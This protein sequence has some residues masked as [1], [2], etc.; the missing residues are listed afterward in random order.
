[1]RIFQKFDFSAL[2]NARSISRID[3]LGLGGTTVF[4]FLL[5][6]WRTA[7]GLPYL[8]HWDEHYVA[9]RSLEMLVTR[10]LNPHYFHYGS[11]QMYLLLAID[12]VHSLYLKALPGTSLLALTEVNPLAYGE[13]TGFGWYLS[14][15]SFLFWNRVLTVVLGALT[16]AII[17]YLGLKLANRFSAVAAALLLAGT[18][19]HVK[20]SA[21]VTTDIPMGFFVWAAVLFSYLFHQNQKLKFLIAALVTSGL[22]VSVKYN[23]G[24]VMLVPV[25]VLFLTR[26]DANY[27]SW[28]WLLIPAI[29]SL[30]FFLTTPYALIDFATF[31]EDVRFDLLSYSVYGKSGA[32]VEPGLAH[33]LYQGEIFL[34]NIGVFAAVLALMGLVKAL[35]RKPFGWILLAF[36]VF[37]FL[38]L[39]QMR[40]SYHRNFLVLYPMLALLFGLGI[41]FVSDLLLKVGRVGRYAKMGF[42][43]AVTLVVMFFSLTATKVSWRTWQRLESR[44]QAVVR[45][46]QLLAADPGAKVG[47]AAE[48]RLHP[49]DL[50]VLDAEFIELPIRELLA[51]PGRYDLIVAFGEVNLADHDT[52]DTARELNGLLG[53]I[54]DEHKETIGTGLLNLR[55]YSVDP[56]VLLLTDTSMLDEIF[57]P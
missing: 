50:A 35:G 34:E 57:N 56:A 11:L 22:A 32:T 27:R 4:A 25:L 6:L 49:Q 29:P 38:I 52:R 54:P 31:F 16:V 10:D 43:L 23:A 21:F 17:Y 1:M 46:N 44:S 9:F 8:H 18:L 5:R 3:I 39:T 47:I 28:H 48:L 40:I 53:R 41:S 15:P 26:K 12:W 14:H 13:P 37:Y 19:E 51:D 45:A 55:I 2:F 30:A 42:L 24:M 7:N 20:H 33:M 36:P